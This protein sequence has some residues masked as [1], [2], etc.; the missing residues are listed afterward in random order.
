MSRLLLL[1]AL[2]LALC[3]CGGSPSASCDGPP[4][5]ALAQPPER[6]SAWCLLELRDGRVLPR[7]SAVPYALN[8][9]LFSDYTHKDRLV[10]LPPGTRAQ[11][12]PSGALDLP[13]GSVVAKTFSAPGDLRQADAPGL[14]LE[15]RLMVRTAEGWVGLPYVW[16][17]DGRDATLQLGGAML[18][19]TWTDVRGEAR[20]TRYLVPNK[21]QCKKCH[22]A[23]NDVR[24]H[25]LGP[26]A[27][28]LNRDFP[29]AEGAENQLAHW[30][31]VGVLEG[32]PALAEVPRLA[33]WN[34][35]S[36]GSVDA[37]ARAYLEGNCAHCHSRTGAARTSGLYLS[38][39][40]TDL[41]HLGVCKR[42]VAAG[43]GS[44]NLSYD[45]VPS[46]P[47]ASILVYRLR[48]TD[49]MLA[50]PE[51]GRSVVHEEGLALLEQWI[52][53]LPGTCN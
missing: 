2:A 27:R 53:G 38:A 30:A 37:R 26:T 3:G 43:A 5:G 1:G 17:A 15:T 23:E 21:N 40:E 12:Q 20:A 4:E 42:P 48:A 16:D 8:T 51:V 29:Y 47:D 34:D 25:L 39:D 49:P 10:W 7:G 13:V 18:D 46:A 9:P 52:Q 45:I 31:R 11:Y 44:G 35:P 6:L 32:A 50:M 22:A 24:L 28:Q 33:V 14:P 36:T 19:V 41:F